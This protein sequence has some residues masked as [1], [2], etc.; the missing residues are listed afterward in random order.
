MIDT[1][2]FDMDGLLFDTERLAIGATELAAKVQGFDLGPDIFKMVLGTNKEKSAEVFAIYFPGLDENIFWADFDKFMW[3]KVEQDGLP[4]KPFARQ[5]LEWAEQKGL[6]LGLCSGSPRNVVDG[7]MR[8]SGFKDFFKAFV[9]GDDDELLQS[10]PAPDMYLRTAGLLG[11]TPER[12]LVLEDSPN[13]LRA[14]RAAGMRT[15][16]VPDLVP[17]SEALASVCDAVFPDLSHVPAYIDKLSAC[18]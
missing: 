15:V 11:S 17:Y 3:R 7:Y 5:L 8:I 9:A 14:G 18:R 16:M 10:K 2:L 1:V 6:A 13:G 4:V 12:C